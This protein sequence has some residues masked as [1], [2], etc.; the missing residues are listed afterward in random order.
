MLF[1]QLHFANEQPTAA[2]P[3]CL[4]FPWISFGCLSV[5]PSWKEPRARINHLFV[6]LHD[7][8]WSDLSEINSGFFRNFPL[9]TTGIYVHDY[10][11]TNVG[12]ICLGGIPVRSR[13]QAEELFWNTVSYVRSDYDVRSCLRNLVISPFSL[14][15]IG[16][17]HYDAL[18][19][20]P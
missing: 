20:V 1:K 6:Y 3:V 5:E 7:Q 2:F 15:K 18:E 12:N 11:Y 19:A 16:K 10:Y 8:P 17:N 14:S 13:E 4:D 9:N